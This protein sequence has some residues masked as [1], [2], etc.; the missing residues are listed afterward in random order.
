[1]SKQ[2]FV[3]APSSVFFGKTRVGE[4][5]GLASLLSKTRGTEQVLCRLF[6]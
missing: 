3:F 5:F 1:M 4:A 6:A 2:V